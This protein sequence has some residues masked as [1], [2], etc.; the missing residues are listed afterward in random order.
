MR[1]S[2]I[3]AIAGLFLALAPAQAAE[4]TVTL[5]VPGMNCAACPYIVSG[6]LKKVAGVKSVRTSLKQRTAVVVYDDAQTGVPQLTK[7][8]GAAGYPSRAAD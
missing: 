6:A 1:H 4:R 5:K 7:A 3:I 2:L 8:T